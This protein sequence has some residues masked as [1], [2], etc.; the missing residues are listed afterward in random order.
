M[1][2]NLARTGLEMATPQKL[3][4]YRGSVLG[5]VRRCVQGIGE[6]AQISDLRNWVSG[7]GRAGMRRKKG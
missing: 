7:A 4:K 1:V 3:T 6:H 2:T 5:A